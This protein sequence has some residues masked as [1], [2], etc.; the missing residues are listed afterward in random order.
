VDVAI[1]RHRVILGWVAAAAHAEDAVRHIDRA[2]RYLL[3]LLYCSGAHLIASG[4]MT[5][6]LVRTLK[7]DRPRRE[8][9]REPT[10]RPDEER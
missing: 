5:T 6:E 7:D 9:R 1:R 4:I 3:G 10:W 8:P 2:G